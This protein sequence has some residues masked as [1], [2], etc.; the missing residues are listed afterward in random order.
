MMKRFSG[1]MKS[2]FSGC[3]LISAGLLIN[4]CSD[5]GGSDLIVAEGGISGTGIS[6]G[7]ITGFSS[8]ILNGRT[9]EVTTETEVFVDE[10]PADESALK[11]GYVVRVDADFDNNVASRIDYVETVRGPLNAVPDINPDDPLISSMEILK[12][13]V[14]TNSITVF[15]GLDD[16]STLVAGDVL[17]VSGVRNSSGAI[18]ARYIQLKTSPVNEYRVLGRAT[19]VSLTEFNIGSLTVDLLGAIADISAFGS[20]G[21]QEGDEVLVRAASSGFISTTSTLEATKVTPSTLKLS[22]SSGDNLELEGIITD[23]QSLSNLVIDDIT[24]DASN[25]VIENGS[26]QNLKQDMLVEVEGSVNE[27]GVLEAYKIKIVPLAN[28]RVEATVDDVAANSITVLGQPFLLDEKTLLKDSSSL[29]ISDFSINDLDQGNWV[30]LRA[31]K[32]DDQVIL[33]RLERDDAK[34]DV[35]I[36]GPVE[37]VDK[38][39][40]S[41]TILGVELFTDAIKTEF[42]DIDNQPILQSEF[43]D[44]VQE[45]DLVRCKWKDFTGISVEVDELSFEQD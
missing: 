10:K 34:P 12:Q 16:L 11:I 30:E 5:G 15:D 17:E 29:G 45:S 26:A 13:Q 7:S 37:S 25:A 1:K 33:S 28:I 20:N 38:A 39:V 24:I 27:S 23:F 22:Y 43:F 44:Q 8:V 14:L 41:V 42:K 40:N 31:Y 19:G 3:L 18:V 32:L 36:Q 6:S 2:L 35:R 4:A 21:I 9:L